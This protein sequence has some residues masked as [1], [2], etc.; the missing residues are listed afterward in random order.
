MC[1]VSRCAGPPRGSPENAD[2]GSTALAAE[3]S[4]ESSSE[5]EEEGQE[6]KDGGGGDGRH[7]KGKRS[8]ETKSASEPTQGEKVKSAILNTHLNMAKSVLSHVY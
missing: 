7:S 8:A 6:E 5:G 2:R 3:Y 4:D 1:V